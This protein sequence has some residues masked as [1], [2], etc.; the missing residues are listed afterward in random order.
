MPGWRDAEGRTAADRRQ[1]QSAANR[2]DFFDTLRTRPL[3]LIRP[4]LG[5]LFILVLVFAFLATY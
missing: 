5:A 3:S 4:V 1:Q 2:A